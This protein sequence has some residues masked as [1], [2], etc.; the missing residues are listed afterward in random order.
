MMLTLSMLLANTDFWTRCGT[1]SLY[2]REK[3]DL[4]T[5]KELSD[6]HVNAFHNILKSQFPNIKG[7]QSTLLQ[8]KKP[9]PKKDIESDNGI[10]QIIHMTS[11][12]GACQ[13][14]QDEVHFYDSAYRSVSSETLDVIT[15]LLN[16]ERKSFTV[17]VMNVSKQTGSVDC[18]LYAMATI[19]CLAMH[20]DPTTV[21]FHQ[22]E[23]HPHLLNIFKTKKVS[24]FP[25]KMKKKPKNSVDKELICEVFCYCRLP[26]REIWFVV[27]DV[28]N[29]SM[30]LAS[31]QL[32][33]MTSGFVDIVNDECLAI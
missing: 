31:I 18:A 22:D 8:N 30:L 13:F 28:E 10:L 7:L 26:E 23:M 2:K 5:G 9:I 1:I 14:F 6:L 21:V 3:Q 17:K 12:W 29:G 24:A 19:T 20:D 4:L 25:V 32:F 15:Q 16:T 27:T 11:H 33:L